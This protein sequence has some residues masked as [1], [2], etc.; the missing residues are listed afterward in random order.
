MPRKFTIAEIASALEALEGWQ[1]GE[2]Q[3]HRECTFAGHIEAVGFVV[4]VAMAAEVMDHHPDLRMVYNRVEIRLSS[5][6]AG[7]VTGRD[8]ALAKRINELL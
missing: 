7:G 4:R 3:I 5:H 2:D 8:I 6:D 1:A